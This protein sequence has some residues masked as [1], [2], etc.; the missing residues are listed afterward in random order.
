MTTPYNL[1]ILSRAVAYGD[2]LP[3]SNPQRRAFDWTRQ[4]QGIQ[5]T[6]PKTYS[7]T[8]VQGGSQLVF[9]GT[10]STT[11][12]GTTQF[13]IT[14]NSSIPSTYRFSFVGGTNPSLRTNRGLALFTA[15]RTVTVAALANQS[16]T[17]TLSGGTWGSVVA[18][19]TLYIPG[20]VTNDGTSPFNVLNQGY[21]V[22]LSNPGATVITVA[23]P[24]GTVFSA[25]S[26]GPITLAADSNVQAYSAAGVQVGDMVNLSAGFSSGN[27]GTY[28]VSAVTTSWFEVT[29][30][31]PLA[32]DVAAMPGATGLVFYSMA[33]SF[34]RIESDQPVVAQ[35][36]GSTST[37]I[38][39][40]NPLLA[41]DPEQP[42][43][44]ELVGP[45][46]SLTLLNK[47]QNQ[48]NCIVFSAEQG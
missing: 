8:L 17:L 34:I 14:L 43:W 45:V 40:I 30:T 9:D 3:S 10:R 22:V 27:F 35:L 12:D 44:L 29:S 36:N 32:L 21:W 1:N 4:F 16:A 48:A 47:S 18:G 15:G 31:L 46:W 26:E 19:D 37:T 42:G 33:K 38:P 28:Q 24:V 23:R 6:N 5:V 13:T 7:V 39:T 20:P 11:L 41:G 2:T 25:A